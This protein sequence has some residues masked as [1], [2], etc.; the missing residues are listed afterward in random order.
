[1]TENES[2]S[3][4]EKEGKNNS[5]WK[6]SLYNL[7]YEIKSEILGSKIEIDEDEYQENINKIT[8]PNLISYIHDSIQ[9]LVAKKI[10]LAKEEQKEEDEKY[11]KEITTQGFPLSKIGDKERNIYENII[12][13][14]EEK[15]RNLLKLHFHHIL[16]KEAMDIRISDLMEVEDEYEEMK[17]KL[18]YEDGRFLNNDRKDN[19]I[20]II[21]SENSNLKH[22][23]DN[24]EEKILN[25][26]NSNEQLNKK[27]KALT[28]EL[29][30]LKSKLND[31]KQTELNL[32]Q[33]FFYNITNHN[34]NL[35]KNNNNKSKCLLNSDE[36][37]NNNEVIKHKVKNYYKLSNHKEK[38]RDEH[39]NTVKDYRNH[40]MNI[41][42][43][44]C[45]KLKSNILSY[46][47]RPEDGG[48]RNEKK[49]IKNI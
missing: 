31:K 37:N 49:I 25:L 18:K 32:S 35:T 46:K 29:E 47:K 11:I 12:K 8:I 14:L 40:N 34:H 1:M 24:L 16:Q 2:Y 20:L 6:E 19:E 48:I 36:N 5:E 39:N 22:I 7:F 10:E 23:V 43:S 38:N 45:H 3:K 9:I 27:V 21:R 30:D 33:N 13:K 28:Q 41:I 26:E 4:N 44:Q 42:S 15:E 17:T